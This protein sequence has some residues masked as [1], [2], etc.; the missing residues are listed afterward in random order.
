MK[1]KKLVER[2][3]CEN[4]VELCDMTNTHHHQLVLERSNLFVIGSNVLFSISLVTYFYGLSQ[5]GLLLA[6]YHCFS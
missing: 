6:I 4:K 3:V 5:S 2:Y 1:V